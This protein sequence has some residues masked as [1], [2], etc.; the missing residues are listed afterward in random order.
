MPRSPIRLAFAIQNQFV[1]KYFGYILPK[2]VKSSSLKCLKRPCLVRYS[3]ISLRLAGSKY[4]LLGLEISSLPSTRSNKGQNPVSTAS[5][6]IWM[7][8]AVGCCQPGG[9]WT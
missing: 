9:A 5:F 3:R 7:V 2:L 4:F 1:S 8:S 6:A